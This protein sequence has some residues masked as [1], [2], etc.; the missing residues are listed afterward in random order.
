M[1]GLVVGRIVRYVAFDA[2]V[3]SGVERAAVVTEVPKIGEG[4]IP[5][6]D[7]QVVDGEGTQTTI[8]LCV[9]EP[10]CLSFKQGVQYSA[11]PIVGTWHWMFDGQQTRYKPDR[12]EQVG[13]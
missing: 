11:K 10:T 13:A 5:Y 9:L 12:V 4:G 1:Q 3:V 6:A 7:N 8:G 2:L